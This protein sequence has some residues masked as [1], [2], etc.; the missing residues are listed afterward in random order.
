[1]EGSDESTVQYDVSASDGDGN[2]NLDA[3]GG[4]KCG[5]CGSRR[6]GTNACDVDLSK[7][8]CFKCQKFG[9]NSANCPER[10]KG[11]EVIKGKGK[12][13]GKK[14][15]GKGKGFGKKGKMNEVGYENDYDGTDMWWQD[16]GSWW[17][18]QSWFE[19]A[20]VW[21]GNWDESWDSTW[22]E[23]QET[24][25]ESWSWPAMEDQPQNSTASGQTQGVQS[26]VLSP[27]ISEMFASFSTGLLLET[28]TSEVF[29]DVCNHFSNDETVFHVSIAGLQCLESNRLFCNCM[30]VSDD[31][32]LNLEC[33]Q[34]RN[35]R[36]KH[37]FDS[38]P[39]ACFVLA[40]EFYEEPEIIFVS[41]SESAC[42]VVMDPHTNFGDECDDSDSE[43]ET[44]TET[45]QLWNLD[46]GWLHETIPQVD[47]NLLCGMF[48]AGNTDLS[49]TLHEARHRPVTFECG[50]QGSEVSG[51]VAVSQDLVSKNCHRIQLQAI[52]TSTF[53]NVQD[54]VS[55][56][57]E[58]HRYSPV[59]HPLLSEIMMGDESQHWWL[60]D[61]GAAATVM[62]TASRATHGAWVVNSQSDRF[63]SANGSK[64]N[65]D[66]STTLSVWVGFKRNN[67]NLERFPVYRQAQLKCL[68]GGISHNIISTNTLCECG[69]EFNQN[70]Q[71]AE[72]THCASGLR[73]D[74]IC[75]FGG[76]P[77]VKLEPAWMY[78]GSEASAQHGAGFIMSEGLNAVHDNTNLNP[79]SG[80]AEAALETHRMQ[81]HVPYDPRCTIC[82]RGKSTFQ[83]RRRREGALET[84][85]QADFGFLTTRGEM[86][87]DV[88]DGTIKVLVLTE[89]STNCVGYVVTGQ[90]TRSVKN[91]IC[92]WLDHFGL[93]S[94]TSSVVLH[95]DAERAGLPF[96]EGT[97]TSAGPH[98]LLHGERPVDTSYAELGQDAGL[99]E[100]PRH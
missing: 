63:R 88:A 37:F 99:G 15:K 36:L 24:W 66:G 7:L 76:C 29:D 72:V 56:S 70:P 8:K 82:A 85:A 30:T 86:V 13:K 18:D 73:L 77:W 27:L 42:S 52:G 6:H 16:D 67:D 60:L 25:D 34:L 33:C 9:H 50:L 75:N 22:H 12:Q 95:T 20:Q 31:F 87:D 69:W 35:V 84:E 10:K 54:T 40:P 92:K 68:V 94:S 43:N 39:S 74:D 41:D 28:E 61:S 96:K 46:F 48:A 3:V 26:L 90:E 83:H 98:L 47:S 93:A 81:G 65:I 57:F 23:G 17:E 78:S 79:L 38:L 11:K 59:L 64:V 55:H 71:G 91:Q 19:T 2:W 21:N 49:G 14:G 97:G 58:L 44:G 51:D 32:A 1:M 5:T 4:V 62:A 45:Y 89:L 53:L 100:V 80:A